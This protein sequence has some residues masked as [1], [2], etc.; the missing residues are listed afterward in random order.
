[1]IMF[2]LIILIVAVAMVFSVQNAVPVTL[3]FL[4]WQFSASLAVLI[5]LSILAGILIASLFS[6]SMRFRK[7]FPWK[8]RRLKRTE[9]PSGAGQNRPNRVENKPA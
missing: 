2:V 8:G 7:S 4:A 3:S 1:M 5:F 6:L 9:N